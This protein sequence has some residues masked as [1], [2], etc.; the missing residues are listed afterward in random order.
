MRGKTVV[1][2]AEPTQ[3]GLLKATINKI[4][5]WGTVTCKGFKRDYRYAKRAWS[6]MNHKERGALS[7]Q[8]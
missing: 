3:Y 8:L 6:R 5:G 2:K 1:L 4:T 7:A